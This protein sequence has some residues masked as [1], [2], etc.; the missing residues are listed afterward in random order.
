LPRL[1]NWHTCE[2]V[3]AKTFDTQVDIR[4]NFY[5]FAIGPSIMEILDTKFVS[6]L[7]FH[8]L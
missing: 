5:K 6:V 3:G 1:C 2:S 7:K 4:S 8:S